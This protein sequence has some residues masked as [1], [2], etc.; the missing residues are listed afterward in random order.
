LPLSVLLSV[1]MYPISRISVK[2]DIG[3]VTKLCIENSNMVTI[4]QN[5]GQST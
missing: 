2:L 5:I 1:R 4:G 3:T